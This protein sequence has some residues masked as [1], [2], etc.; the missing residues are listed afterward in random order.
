M[1]PVVWLAALLINACLAPRVTIAPVPA[2]SSDTSAGDAT[3]ALSSDAETTASGADAPIV[4]ATDSTDAA[5]DVPIPTELPDAADTA[6]AMDT[7]DVPDVP[8]VPDAPD[9]FDIDA[10]LPDTLADTATDVGPETSQDAADGTG[11]PP[12]MVAI[13]AG[14][15]WMGCNASKDT[16]CDMASEAPQH[17]VTLSGFDI[18]LTET[19]VAQYKQCVNAGTCSPPIICNNTYA[20]WGVAGKEQH[21]VNCVTW[22]QAR[23]FCNWRGAGYD[24]P[25][26]AQWEMAAR[27]SCVLNGSSDSDPN[28][29]T[30]MRTFPWGQATAS[31]D[32]AIMLGKSLPGCQNYST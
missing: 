10:D 14:V 11:T 21:P 26:E 1:R 29:A 9:V 7:P 32:F 24:L 8:D 15:F 13:P 5:P 30:A 12:G 28:C 20:N 19:T 23:Q 6:D 25:T 31:C 16:D 4:D 2:D 3:D 27:G 18:D 17:K 22:T